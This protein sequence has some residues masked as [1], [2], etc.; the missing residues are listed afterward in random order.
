MFT[1]EEASGGLPLIVAI[2]SGSS[3][4]LHTV[5]ALYLPAPCPPVDQWVVESLDVKPTD[6]EG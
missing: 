2:S 1:P 4:P 6:T 3:K 5:G